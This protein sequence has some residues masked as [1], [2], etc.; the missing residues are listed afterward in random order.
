MDL[1]LFDWVRV[2]EGGTLSILEE[3]TRRIYVSAESGEY[4]VAQLILSAKKRADK[5][6]SDVNREIIKAMKQQQKTEYSYNTAGVSHRGASGEDYEKSLYVTLEALD[7]AEICSGETSAQLCLDIRRDEDGSGHFI[8]A[9]ETARVLYVNILYRDS[10]TGRDQ[11]CIP[12]GYSGNDPCLML[13]P[14]TIRD[15]TEYVFDVEE[16]KG[17]LLLFGVD[18]SFDVQK[19][20]FLLDEHSA[21]D[22][23]LVKDITYSNV[24]RL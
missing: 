16:M 6:V 7:M 9:N 19:L 15:M 8:L 2:P 22:A 12:I 21:V 4:R 5:L 13:A 20:Q 14:R 23:Q 11:L 3:S 17:S 18:E 1:R 24:L 10:V